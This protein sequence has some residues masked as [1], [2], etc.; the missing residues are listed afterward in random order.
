MDQRK[1]NE[2]EMEKAT[3]GAADLIARLVSEL[4]RDVS[5]FS[6]IS[7]NEASS[8]LYR[9]WEL[10]VVRHY[11]KE[12]VIA[13]MTADVRPVQ[14]QALIDLINEYWDRLR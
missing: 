12:A 6:A 14:R 11:S 10:K 3:G 4:E 7:P 2:N 5:A 8:I 13:E 1:L 9:V